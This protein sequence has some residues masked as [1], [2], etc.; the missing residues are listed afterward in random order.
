METNNIT[1]LLESETRK[2]SRLWERQSYEND[3]SYG[4]FRYY[5]NLSPVQRSLCTAYVAYLTATD[6][7][8][9]RPPKVPQAWQNWYFG[10]DSK[11]E[12][13]PDAVPWILRARAE[14]EYKE[15]EIRRIQIERQSSWR[16]QEWEIAQKLYTRARDMLTMPLLR[17]TTENDGKTIIIEPVNWGESDI[18][19]TFDV[20]SKLARG[21]TGMP[22]AT[23]AVTIDW[24]KSLKQQGVDPGA[25]FEDL[26][27]KIEEEIASTSAQSD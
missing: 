8:P 18:R 24:R 15:E 20:A 17:T 16:D 4:A 14:D 6:M 19:K 22:T 25:V 23:S 9:S 11:G 12:P 2:D 3:R 7:M 21:S 27:K 13:I 1:E 10:K 5:A 26:V